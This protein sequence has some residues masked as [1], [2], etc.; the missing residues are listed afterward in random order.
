V[1]RVSGSEFGFGLCF[2]AG[3]SAAVPVPR[4]VFR[5]AGG[6]EYAVPR[7]A[8]ELLRRR[9]RGRESGV[10]AAAADEGACP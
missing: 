7:A 4:L 9:R 3:G 1:A 8:A 10:L 2:E 5:F 6:A